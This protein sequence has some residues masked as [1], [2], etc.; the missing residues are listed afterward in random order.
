MGKK[1]KYSVHHLIPTSRGW[2]NV[3]NNKQV[4]KDTKHVNLHRYFDNATP[5]EELFNILAT[6]H[7]VRDDR[8]VNDIIRVLDSHFDNYYK[9]W[10]HTD[11]Q[12][13]RWQLMELERKFGRHN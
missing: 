13:E 11:I 9:E 12:W 1:A 6:N 8:F 5:A 3:D 4:L 10:T 2:Q 7:K